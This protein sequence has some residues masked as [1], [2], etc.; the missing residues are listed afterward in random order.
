MNTSVHACTHEVM[1]L[2]LVLQGGRLPPGQHQLVAVLP[3]AE[4][5]A[6]LRAC[7][8]HRVPRQG[9]LQGRAEV[10]QTQGEKMGNHTMNLRQGK[11]LN[12]SLGN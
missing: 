4:G 9:A 3:R 11:Q 1:T 5:A 6:V 7:R 12:G 2:V 8:L 10:G